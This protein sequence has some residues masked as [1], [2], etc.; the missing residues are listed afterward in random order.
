MPETDYYQLLGVE[1]TATTEEIKKSYKKLALKHHPVH[2][3]LSR[4]KTPTTG[5]NPNTNSPKFHK[6]T[7]CCRI[8]PKD[9]PTTTPRLPPR[10][11][12]PLP[13][14]NGKIQNSAPT[15]ITSRMRPRCPKCPNSTCPSRICSKPSSL[16]PTSTCSLEHSLSKWRKKYSAPSSGKKIP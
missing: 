16:S 3:L 7:L 2:P 13:N 14:T 11:S 12:A 5:N 1:R 4:I 6:P 15:S 10:A 8:Q 9:R